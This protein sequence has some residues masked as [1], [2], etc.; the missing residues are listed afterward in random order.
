MQRGRGGSS[1]G[2]GGRASGSALNSVRVKRQGQ[3][4]GG[5]GPGTPTPGPPSG[6]LRHMFNSSSS[7]VNALQSA[8]Q[9]RSFGSSGSD[10][11][12]PDR[13]RK[14]PASMRVEAN[15]GRRGGTQWGSRGDFV[16]ARHRGLML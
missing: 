12:G 15:Q 9:D 11:D 2:Q 13:P 7:P 10:D 8:S 5:P 1:T 3:F 14:L 6:S 4:S 16:D